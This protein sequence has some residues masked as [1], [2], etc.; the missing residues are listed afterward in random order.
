LKLSGAALWV[1]IWIGTATILC[2][3]K[4]FLV[5]FIEMF[6][7]ILP[8]IFLRPFLIVGLAKAK[9]KVE[10]YYNIDWIDLKK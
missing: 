6:E 7:Y 10:L 3:N 4:E 9:K 2:N 8:A 5:E 1:I